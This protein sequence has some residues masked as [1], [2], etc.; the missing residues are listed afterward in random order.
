MGAIIY[1]GIFLILIA[2]LAGYMVHI[3]IKTPSKRKRNLL[4]AGVVFLF[5]AVDGCKFSYET[6][7]RKFEIGYKSIV[8]LPMMAAYKYFDYPYFTYINEAKKTSA[9][10]SNK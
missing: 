9:N 1:L 2:C 8:V 4:I 5:F 10:N 3:A 7:N 6:P